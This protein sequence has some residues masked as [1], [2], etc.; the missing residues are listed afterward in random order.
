LIPVEINKTMAA[1][2]SSATRP[3][4]LDVRSFEQADG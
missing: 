3:S 1:S 2:I 4:R